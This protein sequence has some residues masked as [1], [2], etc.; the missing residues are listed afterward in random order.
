[1]TLCFAAADGRGEDEGRDESCKTKKWRYKHINGEICIRRSFRLYLAEIFGDADLQ[2]EGL[3]RFR[4]G[5]SPSKP[6]AIEN[7]E[8][9]CEPSEHPSQDQ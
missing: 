5:A 2:K 3:C 1:M 4:C 8:T 9:V 7:G 6:L